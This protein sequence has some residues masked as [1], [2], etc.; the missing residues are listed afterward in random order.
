MPAANANATAARFAG[1]HYVSDE[2]LPGLRRQRRGKAFIYLNARGRIIH[3]VATVHRIRALAIP[4]AWRD[5]W[6]CPDANGHLQATGRDAAGRKQHRYHPDWRKVRDSAKYDHVIAFAQ[7]LPA[8]RRATNRDLRLPGLPKQ[9][10]LALIVKLLEKTLIRVGNEEYAHEHH[11]YGLTTL[12]DHHVQFKNGAVLFDFTGKSGVHRHVRLH[13]ARL[14]RLIKSCH[15][16]PGQ[17][18][19]CYQDETGQPHDIGSQDVNDY[20]RNITGQDFTAKDFRTWAGTVLAARALRDLQ[21]TGNDNSL[22]LKKL[23][24][25]QKKNIVNAVEAVARELGNT[26]AICRK[27]YIHPAIFNAYLDGTL[28]DTLNQRESQLSQKTGLS[29][30]QRSVLRLLKSACHP[31]QKH[32]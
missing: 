23:Q 10:V 32:R 7:A 12:H 22:P 3:A 21:L 8:I 18:L 14:A 15:Q 24:L 30:E 26:P 20:L 25:L 2:T 4:P 13:D 11:H 29:D 31:N 27:C 5:V 17:H 19:F 6:I 9:K 28:C 16:L 1:L